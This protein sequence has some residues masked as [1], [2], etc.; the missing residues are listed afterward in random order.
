MNA[1]DIK[2]WEGIIEDFQ[3]SQLSVT[4]YTK[5]HGIAKSSLYKWLKHFGLTPLKTESLSFIELPPHPS[6]FIAPSEPELFQVA[7]QNTKG[8]TLTVMLPWSRLIDFARE[9]CP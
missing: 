8:S 4:A 9:V 5:K 2:R 6:S 1:A 7:L 3:K